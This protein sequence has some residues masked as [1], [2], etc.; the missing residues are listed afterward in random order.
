MQPQLMLAKQLKNASIS[1]PTPQGTIKESIQQSNGEYTV[2]LSLPKN[3]T[4]TIMIPKNKGKLTFTGK[5][6]KITETE[7]HYIIRNARGNC[8]ARCE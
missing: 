8:V 7:Q 5:H 3:I 2:E 6:E 4:G 1:L